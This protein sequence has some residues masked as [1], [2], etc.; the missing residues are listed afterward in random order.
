MRQT[1]IKGVRMQLYIMELWILLCWLIPVA[2]ELIVR[3]FVPST[4]R[5]QVITLVSSFL[6]N[7]LLLSPAHVGYYACCQKLAA[8]R[9]ANIAVTCEIYDLRTAAPSKTLLRGFFGVY[10]H[11]VQALKRQLRWDAMRLSLYTLAGFPGLLLI[12]LG[13][14]EQNTQMQALI[15]G[16][17]VLLGAVG[18]LLAWV[19]LRRLQTALYRDPFMIA[20]SIWWHAFKQ[21]RGMTGVLLRQYVRSIP[22]LLVPFSLQRF[23]LHTQIAVSLKKHPPVEHGKKY[24]QIFHTRVLRET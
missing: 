7:R 6:L 13:G 12:C 23:V 3:R 10:R 18:L 2:L 24:S 14:Q 9:H 20:V 15:G 1:C 4:F 17:G 8:G 19:L 16:S 11:P 5:W 21:T 22:L